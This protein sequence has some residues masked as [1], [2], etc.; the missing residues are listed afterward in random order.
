MKNFTKLRKIRPGNFFTIGKNQL[1]KNMP[2]AAI[3]SFRRALELMP[4]DINYVISL[5]MLSE[6]KGIYRWPVN[7]M[8]KLLKFLPNDRI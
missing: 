7:V 8:R 6:K 4:D 5:V 1:E 2:D 3:S